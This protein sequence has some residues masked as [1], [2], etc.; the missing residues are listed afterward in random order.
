[1]F[2]RKAMLPFGSHQ[3]PPEPQQASERSGRAPRSATQ[4]FFFFFTL[5]AGPRRSLSLKLSD[6]RVYEPQIRPRL[7]GCPKL[8][9]PVMI[10]LIT[11]QHPQPCTLTLVTDGS[12]LPNTSGCPDEERNVTAL[13]KDIAEM[14]RLNTDA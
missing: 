6:A 8:T 7:T 1:M 9:E 13:R 4:V 10:E 14:R 12:L 5:V 3:A 11:H 2:C